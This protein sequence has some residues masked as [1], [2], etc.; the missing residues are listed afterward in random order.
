MRHLWEF[1]GPLIRCSGLGMRHLWELD[2]PFRTSLEH[3]PGA[4]GSPMRLGEPS[5]KHIWK[6]RD[7][8]FSLGSAAV[9]AALSN[10]PL[11]RSGLELEREQ[12]FRLPEQSDRLPEKSQPD[13]P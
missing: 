6:L 10:V 9:G 3:S 7:G 8:N 11:L 4:S 5:P 12:H 13:R 2:S 1:A